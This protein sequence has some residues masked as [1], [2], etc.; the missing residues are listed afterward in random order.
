MLHAWVELAPRGH[1]GWERF[2]PATR[3]VKAFD[4]AHNP[5]LADPRGQE[6][7]LWREP[8]ARSP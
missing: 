5:V 3:R 4:G 2:T 7:Q 6:R 1:P 8:K